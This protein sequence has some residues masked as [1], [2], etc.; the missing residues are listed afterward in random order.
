MLIRPYWIQKIEEAWEKRSLVWLSGVRRVG[1]TTLTRMFPDAVYMN[2]D[3][4]SVARRLEDPESFYHGIS[5]HAIVVFD[6]IHRIQDP[7]RVLKIGTDVF[8]GI[9]ILAT[10]S[11][12]LEATK[13]FSDSLTGR[14]A[15]VYLPPVLWVECDKVFHIPDLD[16]RLLYGGLPEMFLAGKPD[17]VFYSEWID[18]F[19]ARDIQEL[20][21]VRNRAGFVKL[22]HL[23]F[24]S[25][26]NLISQTQL[27]KSCDLTRPTVNSYLESL[28]I[29]N[30]VF[31]LP[32]FHG[33]GKREI[34]QQPKC[35]TFDTG[36]VTFVRG[37]ND[38][39]LEDRGIL[40]EHLVLDMI[41]SISPP[42]N[43]FYWRDKSGREIDFIVRHSSQH[44]DAI[45]SKVNPDQFNLTALREFR[46]I[47]P[48]GNN[49]CIS[50]FIRTPYTRTIDGFKVTFAGFASDLTTA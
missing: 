40:W 29:A 10:G 46:H 34:T 45:E 24:R 33:G 11:S 30:A 25:S 19:Y 13:K 5:S 50:P 48:G 28:H 20:F 41:R 27:S 21:H 26:G 18:S 32:P 3:L 38:I 36:F 47:Y 43:I 8:P 7:S 12:T 31:L 35:Y 16:R 15:V 23:L 37:W 42:A 14:K 22:M 1:K 49:Y 17:P 4:P 39:R 6:E 2:C 9:K 44:I